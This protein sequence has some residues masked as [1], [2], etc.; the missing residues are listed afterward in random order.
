MK[1]TA[2][3]THVIFGL[4]GLLFGAL[5]WAVLFTLELSLIK[6]S[7]WSRLTAFLFF[8]ISAGLF[9]GGFITM[10]LDHQIVIQEVDTAIHEG[11]WALVMHP[12]TP[13]QTKLINQALSDLEIDSVRSL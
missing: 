9:L 4:A 11:H 3:K 7:P 6:S 8:S 1:R 10:R 13:E 5:L 2:I 12:R